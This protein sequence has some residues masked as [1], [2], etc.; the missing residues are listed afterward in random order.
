MFHLRITANCNISYIYL[1]IC[2]FV[3][4][5]IIICGSF[6]CT[7]KKKKKKWEVRYPPK[8]EPLIQYCFK[9][10]THI[11]PNISNAFPQILA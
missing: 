9:L 8:S 2:S 4:V 1:I 11:L 10:Y 7:L 6:Y 5:Y 3:K